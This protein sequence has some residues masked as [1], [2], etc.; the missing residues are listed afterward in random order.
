MHEITF[1]K[2]S[3]L[4]T[5]RL[6]A[7]FPLQQQHAHQRHCLLCTCLC[8]FTSHNCLLCTRLCSFTSCHCLPQLPL[9]C[10]TQAAC[11]PILCIYI[12]IHTNPHINHTQYRAIIWRCPLSLRCFGWCSS[13]HTPTP[14]L[15]LP[16]PPLLLPCNTN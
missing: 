8:S 16:H 10:C 5:L 15:L 12:R 7:T 6:L 14:L 11:T 3:L 1:K 9:C 4:C 13:R 2:P